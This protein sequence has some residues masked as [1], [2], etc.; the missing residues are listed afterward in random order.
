MNVI[1]RIK[2]S[3]LGGILFLCAFYTISGCVAAAS[4]FVLPNGER[5]ST[6][7]DSIDT[8]FSS[9][10][11]WLLGGYKVEKNGNNLAFVSF[12]PSNDTP[13]AYWPLDEGYASQFFKH[14]NELYV[15]SSAGKAM[16]INASGLSDTDFKVKPKSILIIDEPD[17]IAC[18]PRG[19]AK[20][21]A[22]NIGS[23]YRLDGTWDIKLSWTDIGFPPKICNGD[24]SVLVTTNKNRQLDIFVIDTET[25]AL[26]STRKIDK[27]NKGQS[28]CEL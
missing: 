9:D 2:L 10:N 19:W 3:R 8:V 5:I 24:L 18:N 21:S 13:A 11:G 28:V 23:C 7:L 1:K 16:K 6:E 14:N 15:M 4:I 22:T 12:I 27:P 25:G 26:L 17:L 20:L